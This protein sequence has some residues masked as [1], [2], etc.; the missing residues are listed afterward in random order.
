MLKDKSIIVLDPL[1]DEDSSSIHSG[2]N[3][4]KT[5]TRMDA[6]WQSCLGGMGNVQ[7]LL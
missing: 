3:F 4:Q 5:A 1:D 6:G 2:N 7:D